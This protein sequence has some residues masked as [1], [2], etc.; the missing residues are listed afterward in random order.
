MSFDLHDQRHIKEMANIKELGAN[1][2]ILFIDTI[3]DRENVVFYDGCVEE[4]TE[5]MYSFF[6]NAAHE[7]GLF[8]ELR[9]VV[10]PPETIPTLT[11]TEQVANAYA[12]KWSEIAKIA[13]KYNVYQITAFGELDTAYI[14]ALSPDVGLQWDDIEGSETTI[15]AQETLKAIRE[16]FD[17]RIGIG[18][19]QPE[20]EKAIQGLNIQ[21]Y[22]YMTFSSYPLPEDTDMTQYFANLNNVILKSREIADNNNIKEIVWGEGG[23]LDDKSKEIPAAFEWSTIKVTEEKEAEYYDR[24]FEMS[25]GLIDGYATDYINDAFGIKDQKA[26]EVFRKWYTRIN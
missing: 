24:F 16:N 20:A 4:N 10:A 26:E 12:R 3:V 23:V 11:T 22:D 17:G 8:V 9:Q 1:T 21:G 2:I 5:A 6:I 25:N 19:S 14:D 15:V 13:Q 18:V 7:N